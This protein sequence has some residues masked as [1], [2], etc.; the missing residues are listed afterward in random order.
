MDLSV[1]FSCRRKTLDLTVLDTLRH[2]QDMHFSPDVE[3]LGLSALD[4][5]LSIHGGYFVTLYQNHKEGY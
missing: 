3:K 5:L 2:A 4:T 1:F